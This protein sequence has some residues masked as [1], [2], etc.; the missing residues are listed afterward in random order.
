MKKYTAFLVT[1]FFAINSF[2][3]ND[4]EFAKGFIMHLKLHNGMITN[5][6]SV[7]DLYIGGIQLVPQYS[8][9]EHLLRAGIVADGFYTDKNINGAFGPTASLKIKTLSAGFFGSV[10]N[11]NINIDH[12]WG[13]N[14]EHL[15]GGGFNAD[16]GN[17]LVFGITVHRDYYYNNWWFQSEIG[18]RISKKIKVTEPFNQ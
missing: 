7:P 2:A 17:L 9:V 18:I 11:L 16:L 12:L 1:I 3:Q 8:V 6:S 13:T 15:I 4:P 14:R 5:F 10:A